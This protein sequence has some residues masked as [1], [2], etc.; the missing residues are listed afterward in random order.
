MKAFIRLTDF[1]K[2]EL[3]EIFSIADNIGEYKNF[4]REKTVVL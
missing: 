4:L 3:Q 1:T 2:E